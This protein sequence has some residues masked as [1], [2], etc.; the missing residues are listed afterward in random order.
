MTSSIDQLKSTIASKGGV[1]RPNNFVVE[2]P[3]IGGIN[4]RDLNILCRTATLPGKQILTHERRIGMEFEKVA[5]GY[6]VDD[7]SLSFLM[8]NDYAIKEYFDNWR[9]LILDE[10]GQT[11]KYKDDYEKRVVI[12]QL[13]NSIPS[14]FVGSQI[15]IG[16]VNVGFQGDVGFPDRGKIDISTTTYSCE[17]IDAFPTSIGQIDF[18]NDLDGIIE[19]TVQLS[20]TNWKPVEAG[21]RQIVFTL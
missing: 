17:L 7:V 3:S 16:P 20:Y 14:V 5:Y 4:P 8:M 18:S 15:N 10:N 9:S 21:Q 19:M 2:L 13:A 6:A 12:H 1:A 11:A